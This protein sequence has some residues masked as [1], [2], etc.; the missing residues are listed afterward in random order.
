[1]MLDPKTFYRKIDA[2]LNKIGEEKSGADFLFTIVKDI[3][4]LFGD[5]LHIH[6]GCI[7]QESEGE[8]SLIWAPENVKN[9]YIPE[10][11]SM[12]SP[13]LQSILK[14]HTYIFDDPAYT[15]Y[16]APSPR[17]EY[18]IPAAIA[19]HSPEY[20]WIIIFELK[21]GWV[22][23]EVEFCLNAVRT[24]L[25][26]RLHSESIKTEKKQA[27]QIQQSLLPREVPT[28]PGYQ[29]AGRSQPAEIVGGDLYDYFLFS[30]GELGVCIGDASGHGLPAALLVRDVVTGLRM[31]L[32]EDKKMVPIF[33]K[34]NRVIFR[35]VYSTHFISLFYAEI[36]KYG[37]M[38]YVNAGHP[39]PLLLQGD[40]IIE[41]ESTGQILGALRDMELSH[42]Y[43][44]IEPGSILF[45]YT[46]A[47]PERKNKQGEQF[48]LKKL[49]ELLLESR[50][51][52]PEMILENVFQT[53]THFGNPAKWQDDATAIVIKREP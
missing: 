31:G 9:S 46:D 29:I 5:D 38:E 30:D 48:G 40:T 28:F 37:N 19:V 7:Y 27:R 16:T 44:K 11:I 32:E 51:M 26:Y 52:T 42:R 13:Q 23:E 35:S 36:D 25:N 17:D 8:F 2:L 43:I 4:Q 33:K 22:R 39:A 49:K 24:A 14:F 20:T 10:N 12:E 1:M 6:N 3:E 53:I 18:T 34:L 47:L 45:M 50:E 41:L 21:S 15:I